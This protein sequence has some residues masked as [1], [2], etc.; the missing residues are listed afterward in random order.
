MKVKVKERESLKPILQK[1]FTISWDNEA[2]F[3][4]YSLK[5]RADDTNTTI[6][7]IAGYEGQNLH[8]IYSEVVNLKF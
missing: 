6:V 4:V 2:D 8:N 1:L 3:Q 7:S 5:N